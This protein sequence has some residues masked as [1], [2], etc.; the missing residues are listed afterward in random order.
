MATDP[1]YKKR[2]A[3]G[4]AQG[5]LTG[6][7]A[8]TMAFGPVGGVVGG[9][10]GGIAGLLLARPGETERERD[11][12]IARLAKGVRAGEAGTITRR[13]MDPLLGAT[14]EE[15]VRALARQQ[16]TATTGAAARQEGERM[17]SARRDLRE[18]STEAQL[19]IQALDEGRRGQADRMRADKLLGQETETRRANQQLMLS[20]LGLG[21]VIGRDL[22]TTKA[23]ET[24]EAGLLPEGAVNAA[25]GAAEGARGFGAM[26]ARRANREDIRALEEYGERREIEDNLA[27][28]R[29]IR[30]RPAVTFDPETNVLTP[31]E[32]AYARDSMLFGSAESGAGPSGGLE[33]LIAAEAAAE[34]AGTPSAPLRS[35]EELERAEMAQRLGAPPVQTST[36]TTEEAKQALGAM[37]LGVDFAQVQADLVSSDPV[38]ATFVASAPGI[39]AEDTV[40]LRDYI[41]GQV[42]R[43]VL[44][45]ED[46]PIAYKDIVANQR[47]LKLATQLDQ[48]GQ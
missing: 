33:S 40:M 26:G 30:D 38:F 10:G 1:Y 14:S 2:M 9:V 43:G 39:S 25:R 45:E 23:R 17:R 11:A 44:R 5:A 27:M 24:Q 7:T 16:G 8:G 34:A 19:A 48:G 22:A 20:T 6:A 13:F 3:K 15:R 47:Q 42:D 41:Q 36:Y 28:A 31:A 12:R 18:A 4:A 37:G 29:E 35:L 32:Q 21:G 46:V